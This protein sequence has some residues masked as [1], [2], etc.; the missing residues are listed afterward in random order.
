MSKAPKPRR[1]R[2]FSLSPH[3][4]LQIYNRPVSLAGMPLS[5]SRAVVIATL[6]F[7]VSIALVAHAATTTPTAAQILLQSLQSPAPPGTPITSTTTT[8]APAQSNAALA[9]FGISLPR[10]PLSASLIPEESII[11]TGSSATAAASS[12]TVIATNTSLLASLYV[13]VASLQAQIAALG[14]TPATSSIRASMSATR[15]TRPLGVGSTG[16]DVTA[17]QKLLAKYGFFSGPATGYFGPL[18]YSAL[19][20]FQ[21]YN[22][23]EAVGSVGP[24]TRALLNASLAK[25]GSPPTP[26]APGSRSS[27]ATSTAQSSAISSQSAIPLTLSKLPSLTFGDGGEGGGGSRSNTAP[28]PDTTPPSVSIISPTASSTAYGPSV[29][30]TAVASDNDGGDTNR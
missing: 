13:Q 30:L 27:A 14:T 29:M 15:F 9:S 18:T 23:L 3:P 25:S 28:T 1:S 26:A 21:T 19:A 16:S 8:G 24:K 12:T 5:H 2:G 7:V 20:A 11:P 10:V 22:G 6:G 17:L 4:S